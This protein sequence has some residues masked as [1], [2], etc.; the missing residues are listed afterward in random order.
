MKLQFSLAT[1]L[2][3]TALV[4]IAVAVSTYVPVITQVQ[5]R[6]SRET[7][8]DKDGRHYGPKTVTIVY[9]THPPEEFDIVERFVWVCPL[10]I[11]MGFS[12]VWLIRRLRQ[13]NRPPVG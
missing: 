7:T 6:E 5:K 3:F 1:L 12:V 11:L 8:R 13:P 2:V 4:A 10:T 9:E